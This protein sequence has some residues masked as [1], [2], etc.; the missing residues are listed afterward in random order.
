MIAFLEVLAAAIIIG[1]PFVVFAYNSSSSVMVFVL[2]G[3][4]V[5]F[6]QSF[7]PLIASCTL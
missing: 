4:V 6:A 1:G 3:S 5:G 2:L 7:I